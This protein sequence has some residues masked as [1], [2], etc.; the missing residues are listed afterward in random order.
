[1]GKK[2]IEM[3]RYGGSELMRNKNLQKKAV[4]YGINK[5]NPFIQDSVGSAMDQL[6]TKVRPKKKYKTDRPELDGGYNPVSYGRVGG[7]VDIHSVILKVA[8]KKGFVLPGHKCTRPGN[9]LE[10]QLK[11]DPQTAEILE[12]YEQPTGARDAV[13]MQHDV[14]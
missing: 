1:M 5:L 7:K 9:P 4:N 3:G 14:D 2:A 11:Y 13:S 10:S 12:I 8:P 6:S